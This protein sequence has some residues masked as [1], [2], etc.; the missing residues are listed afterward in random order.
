GARHSR[1]R[2]RSVSRRGWV[3]F[4]A[5]GVIWGLPYLMI[6]VADTGVSTPVLVCVRTAVGALMLLPLALRDFP[7]RRLLRHWRPLLAFAVLEMIGP[8]WLLSDAERRLPSALTALLIA[9]VPIITVL[10]ARIAGDQDRLSPIRW[11]GLLVGFAGVAL[12]AGGHVHGGDA[13][14]I[15]EV[16]LTAVGY[17]TAPVI[18]AHTL[19][20]VPGPPLIT[21]CLALAAI[22]YAP[23]AILTRPRAVP[24]P[25]VL[26]ALGGLAV[27]CTALA[28]VLFFA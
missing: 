2:G 16:L 9:A 4:A 21:S 20:D 8:W 11:L 18:A 23:A 24:A 1:G 6:K 5:M 10:P 17:A 7:V 25:N 27:V 13:W 15:A 12:L 14:A 19:N 26:A 28:F 22:G 3:L